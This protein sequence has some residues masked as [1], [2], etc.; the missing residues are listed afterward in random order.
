MLS[1]V[2][3]YFT[4]W[5]NKML[6]LLSLTLLLVVRR[7]FGTALASPAAYLRSTEVKLTRPQS[8]TESIEVT[9]SGYSASPNLSTAV[10][11]RTHRDS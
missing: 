1:Y 4:E 7:P 2:K 10:V 8:L 6:S 3:F 9:A 5:N 11:I